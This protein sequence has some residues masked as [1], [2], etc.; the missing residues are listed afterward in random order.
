ML[1]TI[2]AKRDALMAKFS[3]VN[4]NDIQDAELRGKAKTLKA[5]QGGF[6]LL[7]LLVV[8]A[9]LAAIAGTATIALQGIDRKAQA[10]VN[11]TKMDELTKG[12]FT[13]SAL[14][15][16]KVP[17]YMDSLL[18]SDG[19]TT[20]LKFP[21]DDDTG[22]LATATNSIMALPETDFA[23][24]T[25]DPTVIAEM[26]KVGLTEVM[27]VD[28][29]TDAAKCAAADGVLKGSLERTEIYPSTMFMATGC[30]KA[31]TPA[32]A[33]VYIGKLEPFLGAEAITW[34][35]TQAEVSA[36]VF[37]TVVDG[38]P[39]VGAFGLGQDAS[40]FNTTLLG[41]LTAAPTF[42]GLETIQYN[43]FV[44]LFQIGENLASS[45]KV[46]KVEPASVRFVGMITPKGTA[47]V[48]ELS[49]WDI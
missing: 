40:L 41:G 38:A 16:G 27:A 2:V 20:T 46:G 42:G 3:K 9:I 8:V 30:G 33:A 32:T 10:A 31:H 48:E 17:N 49:K 43:R 11:A 7:E 44:A 18:T 6:T 29:A 37:G 22:T 36:G 12:V 47:A 25:L 23:S 15:K 35:A 26:A 13:F 45:T 39:V 21:D 24:V 5:K 34:D 14:N 4:V 28:V 19:T 1:S